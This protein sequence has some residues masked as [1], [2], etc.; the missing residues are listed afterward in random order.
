MATGDTKKYFSHGAG[1]LEVILDTVVDT[2][3]VVVSLPRSSSR[4]LAQV[5]D[6]SGLVQ[7]AAFT[8]TYDADE[9]TLT[10]TNTSGSGSFTGMLVISLVA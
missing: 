5:M 3:T 10:Y 7:T 6:A 1:V 4:P 8:L 2:G 9:H